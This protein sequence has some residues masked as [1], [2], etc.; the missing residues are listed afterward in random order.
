MLMKRKNKKGIATIFVFLIIFAVII[1]IYLFL[2]LPIPSF[3]KVRA[4]INYFLIIVVWFVFQGL[5]IFG[6][7]KLGELSFKGYKILK[8]KFRNI[9]EGTKNLFNVR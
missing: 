5:I 6:Y 8:K 1:G 3:A 7:F 9:G 2:L 4:I